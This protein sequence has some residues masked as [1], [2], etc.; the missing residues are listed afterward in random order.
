M[1]TNIETTCCKCGAPVSIPFAG[2]GDDDLDSSLRHLREVSAL[3]ERCRPKEADAPKRE[4]QPRLP[5]K[6]E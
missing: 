2:T 3:C 6:D 4:R 1:N 5:Y